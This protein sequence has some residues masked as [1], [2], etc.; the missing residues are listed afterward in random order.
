LYSLFT[1]KV[2]YPALLFYILLSFLPL[3]YIVSLYE[4]TELPRFFFIALLTI[5]AFITL[6]FSKLKSN[7]L[8]WH[9]NILFVLLLVF[10]SAISIIWGGLYGSYEEQI[11]KLVIFS[12]VFLI[13]NIIFHL[14]IFSVNRSSHW[15]I[16]KV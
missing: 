9:T 6:I 13:A 1:G 11:I 3:L 16:A 2:N 7:S 15:N 8:N 5:P 12:F 4:K 14:Y 10:F